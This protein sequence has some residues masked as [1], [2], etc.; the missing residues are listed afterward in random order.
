[1][2]RR[3]RRIL[4]PLILLLLCTLLVGCVENKVGITINAQGDG[5]VT[6][7][8][9]IAKAVVDQ[10]FSAYTPASFADAEL[11]EIDNEIYYV[12]SETVIYESHAEMQNG[13]S[14]LSLFHET[15]SNFFS[16][17]VI[18][19]TSL[20]L[21]TNPRMIPDDV[22]LMAEDEGIT[23]YEYMT[24][25]VHVTM[26]SA[27]ISHTT[28]KLA[29]DGQSVDITF[30]DL[31]RAETC[32][33]QCVEIKEPMPTWIILLIVAGTVA[34]TVGIAAGVTIGMTRRRRRRA[35]AMP[36]MPVDF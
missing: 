19:P 30:E 10:Y 7:D 15:G 1:M 6:Y 4:L 32:E 23:I 5:T 29:P 20:R 25:H 26:P 2:K 34:I 27:V 13:L 31:S 14:S 18:E 3:T 36:D 8:Y 22:K 28:G 17:V 11:R 21:T 16:E 33:I 24:L 12:Y 35:E 9:R